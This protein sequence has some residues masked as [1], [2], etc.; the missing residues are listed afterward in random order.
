MLSRT[1]AG[2]YPIRHSTEGRR[3]TG[4]PRSATRQGCRSTR[5]V[6]SR[7]LY[8]H[9]YTG[10]RTHIQHTTRQCRNNPGCFAGTIP[11]AANVCQASH[12]PSRGN[13][14]VT[15]R[16]RTLLQERPTISTD[17]SIL[18]HPSRKRIEENSH[19]DRKDFTRTHTS[20][21]AHPVRCL[22]EDAR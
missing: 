14:D 3:C 2:F 11:R 7:T 10:A 20:T 6:P 21:H 9:T 19:T 22:P 13:G 15:S 1:T 16:T 17:N 8:T 18:R 4:T 5:A 12:V